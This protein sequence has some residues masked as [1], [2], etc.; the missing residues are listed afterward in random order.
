[1]EANEGPQTRDDCGTSE[2]EVDRLFEAKLRYQTS[3]TQ[4]S[5]CM[6]PQHTVDLGSK[7]E[8]SSGSGTLAIMLA[9][10]LTFTNDFALETTVRLR[11]NVIARL[12]QLRASTLTLQLSQAADS[13]NNKRPF[14]TI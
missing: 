9:W 6:L 2:E 12:I 14:C 8:K 1:M 5:H 4:G 10:L 3:K 13:A 7:K 11:R